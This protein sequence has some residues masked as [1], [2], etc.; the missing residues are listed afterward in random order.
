MLVVVAA[1]FLF[2]LS[3]RQEV[4][5]H[6]RTAAQ[7]RDRQASNAAAAPGGTPVVLAGVQQ[8]SEPPPSVP[9][10][11]CLE[12][13]VHVP[14]GKA[15]IGSPDELGDP[16]EHPMHEVELAAYCIDRTEVTVGEYMECVASGDCSGPA[17]TVSSTDYVASDIK[18][19]SQFCNGN[20]RLEHPMNCVDWYQATTY[21][22]WAGKRL[23]TEAEWE[24]AAHGPDGRAY[25]W[26]N[27][28][29]NST[30]LNS[31][32]DADGFKT[33]SPVGSFPAGVSPFGVL[34]M[35]GNV[36]EWTSDIYGPYPHAR[37]T[38][39]RG[40]TGKTRSLRGGGWMNLDADVVRI[41]FRN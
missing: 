11:T 3:T 21:C 2:G 29:P 31:S 39:L 40:A 27:E 25:P 34:D 6:H 4:L 26:G 17:L 12:R 1:I 19:Y 8:R 10:D 37:V 36:W 15:M 16:D 22:T 13:M 23:P 7:D 18:R 9:P 41:A 33:T 30:R 14:S 5:H 20:D 38:T 24:Y 32:G 35:A 28:P